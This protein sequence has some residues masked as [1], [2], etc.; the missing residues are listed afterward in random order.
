[1]YS[2]YLKYYDLKSVQEACIS[3]LGIEMTVFI[4]LVV[5]PN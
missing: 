2:T 5:I 1:M 4:N 3:V